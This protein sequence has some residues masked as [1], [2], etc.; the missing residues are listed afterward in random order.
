MKNL[1]LA[2]L[3]A[4]LIIPAVALPAQAAVSRETIDAAASD[5]AAYLIKAVPKPA[6]G[7]VG[8]EWLVMGLARSSVTLTPDYLDGYKKRTETQVKQLKGVLHER[9]YSEYARLTL[10]LTALGHNPSSFGG[11]NLLLP[12]GDYDKTVWQGINGAIFAL[13]AL[14]SGNYTM[15][16]NKQA[17]KQATRELYIKYILSRELP[18]GGFNLS[19]T[20]IDPD[21]TAMALQALAKYQDQAAVAGAIKRALQR[22]SAVQGKDGGFTSWSATNCESVAQVIVALTELGI[23]PEDKRFVKNGKTLA[24]NLLSFYTKGKGFAHGTG[25]GVNIMASEQ[26][27]YALV[28]IQRFLDGQSSLYRM[29]EDDKAD[30]AKADAPPL[31]PAKK[32][33]SK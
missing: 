27:F 10:A 20:A 24:D 26:A 9:K 6:F 31:P 19:G 22:L 13:L 1:L 15:P 4:L 3:I 5:T 12:L 16:R 8:G 25:S 18:D 33:G 21:V 14:D 17:A 29:I 23:S 30:G 7:A 11:Y 28:S 2:L 32:A